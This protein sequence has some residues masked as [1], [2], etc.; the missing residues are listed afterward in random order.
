MN[1]LLSHNWLK[2][3]LPNLRE[4]P[5]EIAAKLSLHSASV[6][7][8]TS[9]R[10]LW[11]KIVIGK[12][13]KSWKHPNADKLTLNTV[14]YGFRKKAQ[15]VC[16]GINVREGMFVAYALPGAKVCWH[17][18]GEPVI[19]E[20]AKIRGE[21]SEGMICSG[22]E[23][24]LG[25]MP[26]PKDGILDLSWLKNIKP[27][28][29]LAEALD[30]DD[31]IYEIEITTNRPDMMNVL[32]IAREVG[33]IF[34]I[35][36]EEPERMGARKPAVELPL[37]VRNQGG[38]LC[39]RY[40]AIVF[41]DLRVSESP[42]RIQK[43]LLVSGIRPINNVVDITNYVLLEF[44]QPLHAFDYEKIANREIVIRKAREGEKILALDEA[45]YKLDKEMLV[46]ADAARPI[47]IAGIMGGQLSGV[48]QETT[49]IVLESANF[50][51]V[52]IRKTSRKLNLMS[53]SQARFEK[54]L[55]KELTNIALTRAAL[56]FEEACGGRVASLVYDIG[57]Y[58]SKPK[59]I[60]FHPTEIQQAIGLDMR[61]G[62]IRSILAS[63][64]F[65]VRMQSDGSSIAGVPFWRRLD[66]DGV[67]DLTEE[68]ARLAGYG[69]LPSNL[70]PGSPPPF[71]DQEQFIFERRL[72]HALEDW[73]Y[74]EVIAP[75]FLSAEALERCGFAS[76][77]A[78]KLKN[79][80][81]EERPFLRTSIIPVLLEVISQNESENQQGAI[82]EIGNIFLR[83]E[84]D[85][86]L[87]VPRLSIA[88]WSR[89]TKGEQFF[90]IKGAL[91]LLAAQF[92]IE[93]T[94]ERKKSQKPYNDA[95]L[96]E[97]F[98]C[99]ASIG[100]LGE[101]ARNT[102]KTFGIDGRVAVCELDLL[103]ITAFQ[104]EVQKYTPPPSFPPARRDI[105]F[106]V[107][108]GTEYKDI[109]KS[110]RET[111]NLL[112]DI[113]LFDVYTGKGIPE[114]KKSMAFH[115]TFLDRKRTLTDEEVNR[116]FEKVSGALVRKF[117]AE[118]RS[119]N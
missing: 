96:A 14:E 99:G 52:S 107:D 81:N 58:E 101:I 65:D 85:I 44:G 87:H 16:G 93:M 35:R 55:P 71:D 74:I 2:E 41:A 111:S 82:F 25:K 86:P 20:P 63:L 95:R 64:G 61:E 36:T 38:V 68:V 72:K 28:A 91:E 76:V 49:S 3:I 10:E 43:R 7:R 54:G 22:E 46:V 94:F 50:D 29:P 105:S 19:L 21:K 92:G 31:C 119:R 26:Q 108:G 4:E 5:G 73:G 83:K 42:W 1:F 100:F 13:L 6:E 110:M 106:L 39:P 77:S 103:P 89:G 27:G 84:E 9:L 112:V 118:I 109:V 40:Q 45:E 97:I 98:A 37:A 30:L 24:G 32:G 51:P 80:L 114:S 48:T 59:N 23:I 11:E 34:G 116:V 115:L 17:G 67:H 88:K 53:E 18:E 102:M 78:V 12:V 8:V 104:T 79:P 75:P 56:L 90:E 62:E 113:D 47:A 70:L 66:I 60:V 117:G 33:A 57:F 15:V 69:D